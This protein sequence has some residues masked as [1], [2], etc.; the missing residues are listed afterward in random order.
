MSKEAVF[1]MKLETELR[2]AFMADARSRSSGIANRRE[3]MKRFSSASVEEKRL[4]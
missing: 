3:L 1:T 2:D 4:R